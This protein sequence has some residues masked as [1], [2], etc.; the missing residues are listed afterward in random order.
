[1]Q[2]V[3]EAFEENTVHLHFYRS[4]SMGPDA[5]DELLKEDGFYWW[6]YQGSKYEMISKDQSSRKKQLF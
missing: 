6:E 2:P 1:M 4:G 3:L 5:S